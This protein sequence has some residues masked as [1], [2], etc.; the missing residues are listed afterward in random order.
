MNIVA[1]PTLLKYQDLYP[2]AREALQ[3]WYYTVKRAKWSHFV[4]LRRDYPKTDYVGKDHYVFDLKGN[5]YRLIVTIN[6]KAQIVFIR[7]SGHM[8]NT[9]SCPTPPRYEGRGKGSWL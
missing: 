8:P 9:I 4:E 2:N 1:R 7:W 6:F 3:T 5:N